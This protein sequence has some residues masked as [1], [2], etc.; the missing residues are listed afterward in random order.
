M[1]R[2][3]LRG[4]LGTI[5]GLKQKIKSLPTSVAHR[6]ASASAPQM[7]ARTRQSYA[8]GQ[9]V[10][11]DA[12]P[13][14]VDGGQLDL[15]ETGKVS[16]QLRFVATG[17]IIRCVLGTPYAKYLIGKYRILPIR[18]MP[19]SW[20]RDLEEIVAREGKAALE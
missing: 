8:A 20:V 17:T 19:D 3:G 13:A 7:T 1:A 15:Y 18:T 4:D 5:R 16:R 11:G 12:R 2:G 14:G 10:F 6:V 9:T